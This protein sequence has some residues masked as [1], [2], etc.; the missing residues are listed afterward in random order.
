MCWNIKNKILELV[1]NK[2]KVTT[3]NFVLFLI[4]KTII[5]TNKGFQ[6]N[7]IRI[8]FI[9]TERSNWKIVEVPIDEKI[10][11]ERLQ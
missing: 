5:K 10:S 4:F 3:K 9:V 2:L 6:F 8:Y 1:K 11:F 7:V